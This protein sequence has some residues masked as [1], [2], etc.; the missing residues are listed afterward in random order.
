MNP[1]ARIL[2]FG[3]RFGA[4]SS[5]FRS[6]NATIYQ[7]VFCGYPFPQVSVMLESDNYPENLRPRTKVGFH[8][9]DLPKE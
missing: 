3:T 4:I 9:A 1:A 6:L 2:H 5:V 8:G 7:V